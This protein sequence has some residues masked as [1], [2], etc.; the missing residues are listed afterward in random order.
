M[1][2]GCNGRQVV[3]LPGGTEGGDVGEVPPGAHGATVVEEDYTPSRGHVNQRPRYH[4]G[5]GAGIA[6]TVGWG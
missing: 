5:A 3:A 4:P 6:V 2:T 1:K